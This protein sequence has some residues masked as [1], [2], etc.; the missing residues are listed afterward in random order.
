MGS[1]AITA[2]GR[3]A[4]AVA[5]G[6][7][8]ALPWL[9]ARADAGSA[10]HR[11]ARVE[12]ELYRQKLDADAFPERAF[13]PGERGLRAELVRSAEEPRLR[14]PDKA[15]ALLVLFRVPQEQSDPGWW[16]EIESLDAQG[17]PRT[18]RVALVEPPRPSRETHRVPMPKDLQIPPGLMY[19]GA[20]WVDVSALL[21][22]RLIQPG[23]ALRVR[24]GA[25]A[26]SVPVGK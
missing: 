25:A 13:R 4:R 2:A 16:L 23:R 3:A 1:E 9:C 14:A 10:I 11:E 5:L 12:R 26:V 15:V 22:Q 7:A 20:F 24:Y 8:I 17:A 21:Q 18:L 6:A 19:T